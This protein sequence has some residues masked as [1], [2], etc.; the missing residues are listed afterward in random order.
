MLREHV[1]PPLSRFNRIPQS[2]SPAR[3]SIDPSMIKQAQTHPEPR[4]RPL[5]RPCYRPY[6]LSTVGEKR[7]FHLDVLLE[8]VTEGGSHVPGE[9]RPL[10]IERGG[11][12]LEDG[13]TESS[14][15][16]GKSCP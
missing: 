1:L 14:V 10:L 2:P 13:L 16:V 6:A 15:D 3:K 7:R 8:V 12:Q 11:K 4:M 9:V 5:A